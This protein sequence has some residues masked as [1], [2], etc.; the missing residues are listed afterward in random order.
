MMH[1]SIPKLFMALATHKRYQSIF[2]KCQ[3][4]ILSEHLASGLFRMPLVQHTYLFCMVVF[5][6]HHISW[7]CVG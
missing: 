7:I 3:F 5:E 4:K 2:I 1:S 6:A